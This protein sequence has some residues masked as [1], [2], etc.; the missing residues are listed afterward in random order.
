MRKLSN[1]VTLPLRYIE[2]IFNQVHPLWCTFAI[3]E[4]C[5]ARC[6]YCQYW[7]RKHSELS[8]ED[9]FKIIRQIKSL[10]VVSVVFSGG[11]CMLRP[12]LAEV[13]AYTTSLGLEANVVSNGL[14]SSEDSFREMM[15]HGL[16][17]LTFSL[18]GSKASTH[19]SFRMGCSFNKLMESIQKAVE[20]R[21]RNGFT[22]TISTTTVI[23]KTNINDL[24]NIYRLRKTLRADKNYFQPVWPI[25]EEKRFHQQFGFSEMSF[26]DLQRVAAELMHIPKGNLKKYYKLLPYMYR[27]IGWISKRYHCYAGRAFIY[28]DSS[29]NLFPCSPL[30]NKK[31]IGSL[32]N[33]NIKTIIS[34]KELK[35]KLN[36]Y[37][38]FKCGGCSLACYMEKNIV[39]SEIYHPLSA[40][41]R[42][43]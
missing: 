20:I 27:N 35:D 4:N 7:R 36:N 30:S 32:L 14:I 24:Q 12:D 42:I 43:K 26:E 10:G 34:K 40:W 29:G 18:D 17:G 3:T 28:V 25:F 31:P 41:K 23:N 37:K 11:E 5:N 13:I 19:E 21:K 2:Y 9:V 15:S 39:L 1:L 8:T 22:T 38:Q 16:S 6:E 33:D